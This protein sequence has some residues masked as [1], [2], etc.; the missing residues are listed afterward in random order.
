MAIRIRRV[1]LLPGEY[2]FPIFQSFFVRITVQPFVLASSYNA[3]VNSITSGEASVFLDFYFNA[4]QVLSG[5]NSVIDL[6]T[7]A[8]FLP[9][10]F[11]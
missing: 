4:V 2:H 10:F 5:L 3:C 1:S 9:R 11:S 6:A 7:S 8:V